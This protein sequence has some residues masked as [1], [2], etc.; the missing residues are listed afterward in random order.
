MAVEAI[1]APPYLLGLLGA[2]LS[3]AGGCGRRALVMVILSVVNTRNEP[4]ALGVVVEAGG[5]VRVIV[6]VGHVGPELELVGL[7]K[8]K[9]ARG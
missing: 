7:G 3:L 2:G 8:G 9:D 1:R 6:G 4:M 5:D